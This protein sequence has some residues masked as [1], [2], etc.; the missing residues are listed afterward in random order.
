MYNIGFRE[1]WQP[2]KLGTYLLFSSSNP[3]VLYALT[4]GEMLLKHILA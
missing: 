4:R 2:D 3:Q 1:T